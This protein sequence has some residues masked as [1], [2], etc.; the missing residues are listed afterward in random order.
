MLKNT[1]LAAAGKINTLLRLRDFRTWRFFRKRTPR[2]IVLVLKATSLFICVNGRK[3]GKK[4]PIC[5]PIFLHICFSLLSLFDVVVRLFSSCNQTIIAIPN[6][7]SFFWGWVQT[8][9]MNAG[10][11]IFANYQVLL[12]RLSVI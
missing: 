4:L 7:R 12:K 8:G 11:A 9:V 3:N 1:D 10:V 2:V 5:L 6:F